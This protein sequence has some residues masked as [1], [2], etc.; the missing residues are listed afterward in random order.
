MGNNE[1]DDS[2]WSFIIGDS[3]SGDMGML[4]EVSGHVV[5]MGETGWVGVSRPDG[6]SAGS[7]H[8]VWESEDGGGD[9]GSAQRDCESEDDD[10]SNRRSYL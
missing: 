4:I 7:A 2:E 3:V 10:E 1:S 8:K 6:I 5:V 9:A